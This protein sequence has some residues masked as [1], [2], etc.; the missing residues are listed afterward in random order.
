MTTRILS[1]SLIVAGAGLLLLGVSHYAV[2]AD[3]FYKGK[4]VTIMV[5]Y[6]PGGG[7][8]LTGR[9]VARHL[10]RNTAGKPKFIVKNMPGAGGTIAVNYVGKAAKADGRTAFWGTFPLQAQLLG[11][12]ALSVDLRKFE[13]IAGTPGN[14]VLYVRSDAAP[15]IKNKMDIFK[16]KNI[17]LGGLRTTSS[18]DLAARLALEILGVKYKY[19]T[20]FK[21]NSRARA[22]VQQKIVNTYLEGLPSYLGVAVP[23]MVKTGMVIPIY[24]LGV[25][26][27]KDGSLIRDP[28]VPNIPTMD[29]LY[30]MKYG[31]NPSGI[32][33]DAY[34]AVVTPNAISQRVLALAPGSSKAAVSALRAGVE[35][36]K[37]DPAFLAEMMKV[38][39][40]KLPVYP[41]VMAEKAIRTALGVSDE[42]KKY[43]LAHL[44]R[45]KKMSR[46]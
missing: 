9:L 42:V 25:P 34:V 32:N 2:A 36:M 31:K 1:R 38:I 19:V 45:G 14:Q 35:K 43:L 40:Y 33:Y 20:G 10:G 8:D 17:V 6:S 16:N 11:D 13:Y 5:G 21:G 41:G 24:Q 22:A 4:R 15:G 28:E 44:A 18:K 7:S 30:K 46:K 29:Q 39:K 3:A 37:N 12:K 27:G 23:T 26:L